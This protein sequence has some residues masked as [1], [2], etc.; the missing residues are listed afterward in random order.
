VKRT[1]ANCRDKKRCE[2]CG[3]CGSSE[4]CHNMWRPRRWPFVV[5][6]ITIAVVL[7]LAATL[8]WAVIDPAHNPPK[9]GEVHY[10]DVVFTN[11][12]PVM[13]YGH[14]RLVTTEALIIG[15]GS[16]GTVY[17]ARNDKLVKWYGGM[18]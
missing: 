18:R 7:V 1:C 14:A 13:L 6:L 9:R 17:A 10:E 8:V 12:V 15:F 4:S 16:N 5:V 2:S 3:I 11:A